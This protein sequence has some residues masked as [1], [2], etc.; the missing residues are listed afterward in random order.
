MASVYAKRMNY[1]H[2]VYRRKIL[3]VTKLNLKAPPTMLSI[4]LLPFL[5]LD[6]ASNSSYQDGKS[7]LKYLT[8]GLL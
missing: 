1:R 5:E 3:K 8:N 6:S 2:P 7:K 4:L